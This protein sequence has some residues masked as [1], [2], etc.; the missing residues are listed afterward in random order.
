MDTAFN[1][2]KTFTSSGIE[3]AQTDLFN[4]FILKCLSRHS[5]K[6]FGD[7]EQEDIESNLD[8]LENGG[9]LLSSY[10]IPTNIYDSNLMKNNRI[11]IITE[12]ER[13][14]TT[15]FFPSEY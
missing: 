14:Y 11:W 6:D 15:I 2:G 10:N 1:I 12:A 5:N 13:D 3:K 8:A 4:Q 9:R 7:L